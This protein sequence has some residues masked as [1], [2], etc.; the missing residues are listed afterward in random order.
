MTIQ[1]DGGIY[2][3]KGGN[4]KK[5]ATKG[6]STDLSSIGHHDCQKKVLR[7]PAFG[8]W[9]FKMAAKMAANNPKTDSK[10]FIIHHTVVFLVSIPMFSWSRNPIWSKYILMSYQ[11][12]PK[13]QYGG[14]N[15]CQNP[16]NGSN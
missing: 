9:F 15:S 1:F 6:F 12:T 7:N 4:P 16:K 8:K 13:I 2:E 14:Q 3:N 11:I 5:I 10:S